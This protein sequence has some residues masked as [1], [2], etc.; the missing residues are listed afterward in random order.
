M[1][2]MGNGLIQFACF[3]Q[4]FNFTVV[5]TQRNSRHGILLPQLCI[6]P[7]DYA[8]NFVDNNQVYKWWNLFWK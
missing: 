4:A 8:I 2:T 1:L 6:K 5:Y 3:D 7:V